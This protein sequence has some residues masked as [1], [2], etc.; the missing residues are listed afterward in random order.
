MEYV[1]YI[2]GMKNVDINL[3]VLRMIILRQIFEQ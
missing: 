3:G 1:G 2:C